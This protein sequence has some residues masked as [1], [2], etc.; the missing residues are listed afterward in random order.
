MLTEQT[1]NS[2]YTQCDL[3]GKVKASEDEKTSLITSLRLLN[4][5]L[6]ATQAS[7]DNFPND[8]TKQRQPVEKKLNLI[9]TLAIPNNQKAIASQ[10]PSK[11]A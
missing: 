5:D 6:H 8:N 11:I 2:N 1:N 4:P 10:F 9:T 3:H 7:N